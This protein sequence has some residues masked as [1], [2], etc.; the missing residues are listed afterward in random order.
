MSIV[1]YG[2]R[3]IMVTTPPIV[4]VV[5]TFENLVFL[6]II[7]IRY[8]RLSPNVSITITQDIFVSINNTVSG[9]TGIL[10]I[11]LTSGAEKVSVNGIASFTKPTIPG[12]FSINFSNTSGILTFN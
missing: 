10:Q 11:I 2:K 6:Q 8:D 5:T 12:A 1:I 4:P 7:N 3:A 9:D